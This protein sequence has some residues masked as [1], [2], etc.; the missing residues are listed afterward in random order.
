MTKTFSEIAGTKSYYELT[1]EERT[2]IQDR[3]N[4]LVNA[5]QDEDSSKRKNQIFNELYESLKGLIKGRAY[6]EAEKSFSVD[7]EDFE[8]IINLVLVET[9]LTFD[10][11]LHK[12]FQPVFLLNIGNAIKMTYREK[13]YDLHDTASQ[14]DKPI[15]F[16][17]EF[18]SD[19]I[20]S[21]SS[22]FELTASLTD[23]IEEVE[24]AIMTEEM[25]TNC[26]GADERKKTIIHMVLDKY[27]RNEIIT[28][29]NTDGKSPEAVARL[30]NRTVAK[31]R[32]AYPKAI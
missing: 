19:T 5:W 30:I 15:E 20:V 32:E 4:E 26:F 12:P 7:K 8:G 6:R 21:V 23:S 2:A 29:I 25:L 24:T 28:A 9:L 18:Y 3:Q 22:A 11:T 1:N 27:K 17:S 14:L 10:R 13:G 31:F 16:S